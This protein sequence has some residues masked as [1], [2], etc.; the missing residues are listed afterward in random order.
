[1]AKVIHC[2]CSDKLTHVIDWSIEFVVIVYLNAVT[3]TCVGR[4]RIME[5][6]IGPQVNCIV[7]LFL[8][9]L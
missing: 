4:I 1:M 2:D 3:E 7:N 6:C 9:F 5:V 8:S